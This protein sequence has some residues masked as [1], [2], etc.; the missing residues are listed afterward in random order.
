MYW[1]RIETY[2]RYR[3]SGS[4]SAPFVQGSHILL[5]VI[6]SSIIY[7][8]SLGNGL[9]AD[10]NAFIR[11][12]IS[13][14]SLKNITLFFYSPETMANYFP[15]WGT[16]IYRPLRTLSYALDYSL[17]GLD[18]RGYHVTNLL[19]HMLVSIT[20]YYIILDL[21]ELPLVSLL[22]SLIFAI[23]PVHVEPVSWINSRADLI[24][25]LFLNLSIL[26]YIAYKK[27]PHLIRYLV[28][29]LS[30]SFLAYLGKET[31]I[32]LPGLIILYD[33]IKEDKMGLKGLI[34]SRVVTW[35]LFSLLCV[36]YLLLRFYV[37]GRMTQNQGWW[38][39]TAY[40]NFLMMAKVTAIYIGLIS[41]PLKLN[42]HYIIEPIY[43][44]FNI[45]LLLALFVILLS[46]VTIVYF[47]KRNKPLFFVLAWFYI[48]LVPIANIIPI[49]FSMMAERYIYMPSAGPIIAIAY[50]AYS[51]YKKV[52]ASGNVLLSRLLILALIFIFT[53]FSLKVISRNA[54]YRD[55]FTLYTAAIKDSPKSPPSYKGLGDWYF[56]REEHQ[57]A[58]A[59]Y[60]K[61]ITIDPT[62]A[63][64]FLGKAMAFEKEM[65]NTMARF[66]AEKAVRL[67]PDEANIRYDAGNIYKD[68][69]DLSNA[70]IQW[71]RA[72]E[73]NPNYSEA[74]NHLGNYY[75][76]IRNYEQAI[77]MYEQ[78]I[79]FNP[80]NAEG[81]YNLAI[82]Y[83]AQD[84][85]AKA[86][87]HYSRFIDLAGPKYKDLVDDVARRYPK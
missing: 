52:Y 44:V 45:K 73:L 37:A 30:F 23:H 7:F 86:K 10:D 38:G 34:R 87:F 11:D 18:S 69:G 63:E 26:S 49:S 9:L 21:F 8:N 6:I 76:G 40:S 82:I 53:I 65:D 16:L 55:D 35:I 62:Y 61:A 57:K 22:G 85:Q 72:I 36:L 66:M 84:S 14:R 43:T 71:E 46:I 51:L 50:V 29:S 83:E 31:M 75:H 24:G 74:Y 32:P 39:G 42:F 77:K 80:Y 78:S 15:E 68:L 5:I 13:I 67:K 81:H 59:E 58:I 41:F 3:D 28:L 70:K 4:K 27:S 1:R 33:Y 54:V 60:E 48:S 19:L 47:H 56:G 20:L 25:F 2:L 17:W 64:A 79:K 12:N